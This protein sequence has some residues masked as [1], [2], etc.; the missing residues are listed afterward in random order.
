MTLGELM[1]FA[2]VRLKD[3]LMPYHWDDVEL[4]MFFNEAEREAAIRARLLVD[5]T[6]FSL[7]LVAGVTKYALDPRII[8]VVG[9]CVNDRPIGFELDETTLHLLTEPRADAVAILIAS[10]M[11]LVPMQDM[12]DEPEIREMHHLPLIDW[13]IRSAHL[14]ADE[15][16][17]QPDVAAL[18]EQG[19]ERSFGQRHTANVLRKHRRKS[20]R[21]TRAIQF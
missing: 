4:V 16:T 21:V 17:F 7:D 20:P 2:R 8:D 5:D 10:R 3:T 15:E 9:V 19:F 18:F 11:P 6:S 13:V 14:R 12:E 1:A